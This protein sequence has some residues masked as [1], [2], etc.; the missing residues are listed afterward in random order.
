LDPLSLVLVITN[1]TG[2]LVGFAAYHLLKPVNHMAVQVPMAATVCIIGYVSWHAF[3]QR[4]LSKRFARPSGGELV[5]V[6]LAALL[7]SPLLFV[8]LPYL[9]QGYL[10][11]IGN[12]LAIWLFQIP[13]NLL[14]LLA[15][16]KMR[17]SWLMVLLLICR[18]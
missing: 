13:V 15:A 14:A 16:T 7:W 10:T 18:I 3:S 12:I 6:Y 2:I 4:V 9:T 1:I 5:W 17:G 11:S 8:P